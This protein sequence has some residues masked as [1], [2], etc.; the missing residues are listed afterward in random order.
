MD[1]RIAA[2]DER[3]PQWRL[4]L[5]QFFIICASEAEAQRLALDAY[6]TQSYNDL[7][8]RERINFSAG[9]ES[10]S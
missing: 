10:K 5:D 6:L 4:Y 7:R 9:C 8:K 2:P 1:I 3:Q